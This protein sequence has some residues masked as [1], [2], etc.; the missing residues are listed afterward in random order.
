MKRRTSFS[1]FPLLLVLYEIATYLSNDMYLP[2]L[3]QMMQDLQLTLQ[4]AQLTLTTWFMGSA[5]MPL[6]MG[7]LTDRYGRRPVLFVGGIVYIFS[8]V[9]CA[10][11]HHVM[12]LLVM[13]MIEGG[14]IASMLVP[15]Y[16]C[17]HE[18][19]EQ[20]TAIRIL[21]FMS[22]V[23]VLAP[24]LGPLFGSIVLQYGTWR[25]IFWII[26]L[27][28]AITLL[29]LWKWMPETLPV[30]KRQPIQ[31]HLLTQ[32]YWRV[33]TNKRGIMLMM[34]LG[35]IFAGFLA[36]ITAAP[37][38]IINHFHYSAILFGV[39]Q[40]IVFSAYIV[41][42][43]SVKYFLEWMGVQKLIRW[44]LIVGLW[45]GLWILGCAIFYPQRLLPFMV[46]MMFYA[47]GV[48]LCFAPLNR[49]VIDSNSE[50]MGVRVTF[51]TIGVQS[52]AVLGSGMASIFFNGSILSLA[53]IISAAIFIAFLLNAIHSALLK[54]VGRQTPS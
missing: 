20:K 46:G 38:L 12:V 10:M 35:F 5:I 42:S 51:F 9:A 4:Q 1:W 40:A 31:M 29:L 49:L 43:R 26:A 11:T 27:W 33:F 36:W 50:P 48:A 54:R 23:V 52:F 13:R 14:M 24:A 7:V 41:A 21:A 25:S 19:Y 39:V 44:G 17:I 45:G 22:S 47:V 8:T 15:G 53:W 18:L 28:S 34:I 32:Q 6:V 30:E 3:P 37:L 16:A 2:A